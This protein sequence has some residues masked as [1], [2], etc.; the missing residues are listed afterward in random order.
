MRERKLRSALIPHEH[1]EREKEKLQ[2][3]SSS[4]GSS[5]PLADWRDVLVGIVW[6]HWRQPI[7][8]FNSVFLS[9]SLFRPLKTV[10]LLL[11]LEEEGG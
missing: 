11:L 10:L 2:K 7:S 4:S 5:N 9:P 8:S 3:S 6:T 1:T